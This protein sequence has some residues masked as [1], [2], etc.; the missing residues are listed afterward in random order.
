MSVATK[1]KLRVTP[2]GG[3]V[4]CVRRSLTPGGSMTFLDVD[5]T[6]IQRFLGHSESDFCTVF[7]ALTSSSR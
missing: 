1:L 3:S 2:T 4:P 5:V 6:T 7:F